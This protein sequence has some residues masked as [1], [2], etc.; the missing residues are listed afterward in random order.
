MQDGNSNSGVELR[1][2]ARTNL[3][4]AATL[5]SAGANHPVKIRDLSATGARIESFLVLQ[6]GAAV[7]LVRGPLSV[8]AHVGWHAERFCGLSFAAPVS[9]EDW[10]AN[11]VNLKRQLG[12]PGRPIRAE[13]AAPLRWQAESAESVAEQLSRVSRWLV[14]FGH[15]LA[16]DKNVVFKHG[17]ELFN[18]GLAARALGALAETMQAESSASEPSAGEERQP[19]A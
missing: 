12:S 13:V 18:L 3:F 16:T 2:A 1:A 8:H 6:V 4:L 9:T 19:A 15:A 11:P 5:N 10:M 14:A 7:T 17:S